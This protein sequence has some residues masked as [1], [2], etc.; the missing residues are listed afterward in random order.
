MPPRSRPSRDPAPRGLSS[1]RN[2][3]PS[4]S[5][6]WLTRG[7]R[8]FGLRLGSL[9][10][11]LD[12]LAAE[13]AILAE[14]LR[15]ARHALWH[16]RI[17]RQLHVGLHLARRRID[18]LREL[19]RLI[20][21][22]VVGH[23]QVALEL[24]HHVRVAEIVEADEDRAQ[25]LLHL[26]RDLLLAPVLDLDDLAA[27]A[28]HDPA[29]ALDDLVDQ[30]LCQI[31]ADEEDRFVFAQPRPRCVLRR[32][33]AAVRLCLLHVHYLLGLPEEVPPARFTSS[34]FSSADC[35]AESFGRRLK[36]FIATA[37][38]STS[39]VTLASDPTGTSCSTV[40]S[41]SGKNFASTKSAGSQ[42]CGGLPIPKRT[43]RKSGPR[44]SRRLL[45]PLWP[46]SP[47]PSFTWILPSSRSS[48]SCATTSAPGSTFQK[49]TAWPTDS[50]EAFMYVCGSIT[51]I[52]SPLTLPVPS[53]ACQRF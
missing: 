48:S 3:L 41:S 22:H 2:P 35:A 34:C 15:L 23:A 47:P 13:P 44:C 30:V 10:I 40:D 26:V 24:G 50:P 11:A 38:P 7:A 25:V 6:P 12:P 53:N 9:D 14:R 19:H 49:R 21:E 20:L 17:A 18:V 31:R 45:S 32:S 28:L 33:A 4:M 1:L 29:Q 5:S 39:A 52:C 37:A 51:A 42:P 43:R 27:V 8:L 46:P 16:F 36:R